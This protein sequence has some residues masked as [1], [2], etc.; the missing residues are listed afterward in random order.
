M[1]SDKVLEACGQE[2]ADDATLL[3]LDWTGGHDLA[4]GD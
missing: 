1:L 2:L 3:V 4:A